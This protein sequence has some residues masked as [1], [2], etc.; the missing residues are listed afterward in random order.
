MAARGAEEILA[1]RILVCWRADV[2]QA[3]HQGGHHIFMLGK[4]SD[5]LRRGA[6]PVDD[7][8]NLQVRA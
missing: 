2:Q 1:L 4:H 5:A 7:Q 6:R 8:R 3:L